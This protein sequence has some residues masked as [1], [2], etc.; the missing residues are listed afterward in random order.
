MTQDPTPPQPRQKKK[1][2]IGINNKVSMSILSE[3]YT[4]IMIRLL[5][6]KESE[7]DFDYY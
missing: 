1:K 3:N 4:G 7:P 6:C 5:F 2:K